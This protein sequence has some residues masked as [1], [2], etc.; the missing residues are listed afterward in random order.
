MGLILWL[1]IKFSDS[2]L[3]VL[4]FSFLGAGFI[5]RVFRIVLGARKDWATG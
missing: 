3:T 4:E 5:A 1:V 2:H